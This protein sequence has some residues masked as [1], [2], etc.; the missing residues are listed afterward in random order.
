M[1]MASVNNGTQLQM[2]NTGQKSTE[3]HSY[4]SMQDNVIAAIE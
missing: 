3:H 4:K 2:A 1:M